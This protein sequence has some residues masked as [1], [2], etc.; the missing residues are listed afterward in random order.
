MK[1]PEDYTEYV[2]KY[3]ELH[4][5]QRVV[6]FRF[7]VI[8]FTVYVVATSHLV[9]EFDKT[10]DYEEFSVIFLSILFIFITW[11][12][13]MLDAR[14]RNLIHNAE[15]FFKKLES[16]NKFYDQDFMVE[17]KDENSEILSAVNTSQIF[18]REHQDTENGRSPYR[19]TKCFNYIFDCGTLMALLFCI[20]S[21]QSMLKSV[22]GVIGGWLF[23]LMS[24]L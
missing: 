11:V 23:A 22:S 7:Y 12:F 6:L 17:F 13:K 19:C 21:M 2:W 5:N 1:F 24:M 4:A 16:T 15:D 9:L 8:F 3:F 14:N 20:L 18:V 10:Q